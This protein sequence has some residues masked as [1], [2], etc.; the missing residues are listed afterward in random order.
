M[1]P[2]QDSDDELRERSQ[3]LA[4]AS[5]LLVKAAQ[6]HIEAAQ[7]WLDRARNTRQAIWLARALRE[8]LRRRDS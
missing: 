5:R 1:E 7:Q 8:R 6:S 3:R 4:D 2:Q